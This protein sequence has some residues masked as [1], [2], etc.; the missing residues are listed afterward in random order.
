M[1]L[2][3]LLTPSKFSYEGKDSYTVHGCVHVL[4]VWIY[5]F[6]LGFG[7]MHGNRIRL[8]ELRFLFCHGVV[9]VS[10]STSTIFMQKKKKH[11][12]VNRLL[13]Q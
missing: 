5:E 13:F 8:R 1:V 12:K 2:K 6:A 10:V 7:E 11:Q 4:V 3:A 9:L